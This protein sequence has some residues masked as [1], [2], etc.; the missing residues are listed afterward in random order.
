[1]ETAPTERYAKM[2]WTVGLV[3]SNAL[4]MFH[5]MMETQK[6]QVDLPLVSDFVLQCNLALHVAANPS[7]VC[8]CLT[9]SRGY[10]IVSGYPHPEKQLG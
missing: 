5:C 8:I 2:D 4:Y 7:A 9:S 1:M 10:V 6:N 3:L